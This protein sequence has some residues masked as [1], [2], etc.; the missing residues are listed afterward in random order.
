[1]NALDGFNS[2]TFLGHIG[3]SLIQSHS[4]ANKIPSTSLEAKL[5]VYLLHGACADVEAFVVSEVFKRWWAIIYLGEL[6]NLTR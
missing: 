1:M 5:V 6:Q 2:T 3:I 4:M